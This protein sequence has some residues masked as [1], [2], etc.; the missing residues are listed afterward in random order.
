MSFRVLHWSSKAVNGGKRGEGIFHG[1]HIPAI[2]RTK[3]HAAIESF[4]IVNVVKQV[5]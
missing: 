2:A 3:Y 1:E 5:A 4:K